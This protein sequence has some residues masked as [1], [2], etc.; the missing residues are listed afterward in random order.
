M[1]FRLSDEK[2]ADALGE[3]EHELQLYN[4]NNT[5]ICRRKIK[6]IAASHSS[7]WGNIAA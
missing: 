3:G 2:S 5:L 4:S 1:G 6:I 7:P